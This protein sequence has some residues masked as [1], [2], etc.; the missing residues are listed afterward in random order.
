MFIFPHQSKSLGLIV[1]PFF[2]WSVLVFFPPLI[3]FPC[4]SCWPSFCIMSVLL[5]YLLCQSIVL[6]GLASVFCL[7][8]SWTFAV[9]LD[10]RSCLFS[11]FICCFL[12]WYLSFDLGLHWHPL[13]LCFC[14]LKSVSLQSETLDPWCLCPVFHRGCWSIQSICTVNSTFPVSFHLT[15]A[16]PCKGLKYSGTLS[17]LCQRVLADC[18]FMDFWI[19]LMSLIPVLIILRVWCSHAHRHL[20]IH[21]PVYPII[22]G[23]L[24]SM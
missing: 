21:I 16:L 12:D 9:V 19:P 4:V 5:C 10:C 24:K 1:F 18:I 20:D 14:F 13:S 23:I 11:G 22:T 7:S 17:G 6:L 8:V 2:F 3:C 15:K